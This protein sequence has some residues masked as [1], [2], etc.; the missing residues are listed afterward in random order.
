MSHNASTTGI[1]LIDPYD[2]FFGED[3]QGRH[4]RLQPR[5]EARRPCHQQSDLR[6]LNPHDGRTAHATFS[7]NLQQSQRSA[8]RTIVTMTDL[9]RKADSL[10][11]VS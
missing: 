1:L 5:R 7:L 2:G 9:T 8:N 3:G 10:W 4:C 6:P 11:R